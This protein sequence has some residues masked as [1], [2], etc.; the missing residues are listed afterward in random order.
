MFYLV[1]ILNR[2]IAYKDVLVATLYLKPSYADT[3]K[4]DKQTIHA[5]LLFGFPSLI[6]TF[7]DGLIKGTID[8]NKV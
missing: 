5:S 4:S 7:S 8:L 1:I 2:N 6:L 3:I